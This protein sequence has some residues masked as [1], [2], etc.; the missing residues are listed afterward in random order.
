M[1]ITILSPESNK[2]AFSNNISMGFLGVSVVVNPPANAGDA[3]KIP[4]MRAWQCTPVF[5]PE[6]SHG[7]RK[8]SGY[9]PWGCR[10]LDPTEHACVACAYTHTHTHKISVYYDT[11]PRMEVKHLKKGVCFLIC[12]QVS[13]DHWLTLPSSTAS[14]TFPGPTPHPLMVGFWHLSS[15]PALAWRDQPG[16]ALL[17]SSQADS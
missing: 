14:V 10:E 6:K 13:T 12:S 8:V 11:F 9:S 5:L 2:V 16:L 17:A 15:V 3:G 4:W 1:L 7:Q